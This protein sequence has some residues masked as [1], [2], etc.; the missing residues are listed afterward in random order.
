ML[1]LLGLAAEGP[2]IF[3]LK[4]RD[5]APMLVAII[6]LYLELTAAIFHLANC[7][8]SVCLHISHAQANG[9]KSCLSSWCCTRLFFPPVIRVPLTAI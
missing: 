9:N 1:F 5:L 7:A 8:F 2:S 3:C 4:V 6:E